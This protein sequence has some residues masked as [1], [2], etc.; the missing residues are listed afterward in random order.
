MNIYKSFILFLTVFAAAPSYAQ[1]WKS[2]TK[3]LQTIRNGA[4]PVAL[5]LPR[6]SGAAATPARLA[7]QSATFRVQ[8]L[9]ASRAVELAAKN[10][11]KPVELTYE[12]KPIVIGTPAAGISPVDKR[13]VAL[14]MAKR[15]QEQVLYN[16]GKSLADANALGYRTAPQITAENETVL[17]TI[18]RNT[19]VIHPG[20]AAGN[21]TVITPVEIGINAQALQAATDAFTPTTLTAVFAEDPALLAG[22]F[23]LHEN[24][25]E[26]MA[27][28]DA[29][30]Q[31]RHTIPT[32]GLKNW[33]KGKSA[34]TK[35]INNNHLHTAAN[36][37]ADTASLL[38]FMSQHEEV[39]SPALESYK[40]IMR[41][42]NANS[43][44]PSVFQNFWN[45]LTS[46]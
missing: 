12:N 22:F 15:Q 41:L 3:A 19:A 17:L 23:Y 45:Q 5:K 25:M 30:A 4:A 43:N 7:A 11:T 34:Q 6:V 27:Q 13:K 24:F 18:N 40:K 42:H 35:L 21:E 32:G 9:Q 14:T 38:K 46:I 33:L 1:P 31:A 8:Y 20:Q 37:A 28:F 26:S 2:G 44:T 16:W 29:A 36:L 39:F 10:I